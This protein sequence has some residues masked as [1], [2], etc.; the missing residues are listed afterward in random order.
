MSLSIRARLTVWYTAVLSLALAA[1]GISFYFV[2]W[3]LRMAALD[4][5]LA[6]VQGLVVRKVTMELADEAS[7]SEAAQDAIEDVHVPGLPVAVFD[8]TG[9]MLA[10]DWA[11]GQPRTEGIGNGAAGTPAGDFRV[12][13]E[14]R[15]AGSNAF[16]VA[17]AAPRAPVERELA[18]LRRALA[19]GAFAA[20]VLA[21]AG[22]WW[23]ARGA[24]GPVGAMARRAGEISDRTPGARL[25]APN[26]HDELGRLAQ[27]F[28]ELLARLEAALAAQ[29]RF[30]ADASHELR[31]PVSIARTAA[32]VTLSLP[33]RTEPE[34]R[35]ALG[36]VASQGR[37]LTR[38]VEDMF[39]LA[40][41]DAVGLRLQPGPL[42]LDELV[43]ECVRD[44]QVLGA[45]RAVRVDWERSGDLPLSA[46]EGLLR[47]LLMNLLD[48]GVRHSPAQGRVRVD[49]VVSPTAYQ[50]EVTDSGGGIPEAD[51]DRVFE[52]FV[53]LDPS[54]RSPEG[55]GLGLPIARAIAEAHGGGLVL[56]RSDA[57]GST[58]HLSLPRG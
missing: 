54:G 50:V 42:Y 12:E 8:G 46:D 19:S 10:G 39:L 16:S 26:P 23:I 35:D 29:R 44:A 25:S 33:E 14:R 36:V 30:M 1:A 52:R 40:R 43:A 58:F 28:N 4:A 38:M 24:L 17:V 34:Y 22:G 49:L 7:L 37:R 41:A 2:Q 9:R 53:R 13:W 51:R 6:R 31:T 11:L 18:L 3:R 32:D 48:N 56:G 5:D 47:Q 57:S 27:A 55:A 45:P 21:A 20:L 15:A